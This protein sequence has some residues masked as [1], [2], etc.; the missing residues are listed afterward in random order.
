MD[1]DD[2]EIQMALAAM[3]FDN[4]IAVK[5]LYALLDD[6]TPTAVKLVRELLT[7]T[8]RASNLVSTFA[9]L[10]VELALKVAA[11][12]GDTA[13]RLVAGMILGELQ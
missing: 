9:N 12:D 4:D 5:V 7:D 3:G 6:D 8:D 13:K 1:R 10:A 11:G 2:D